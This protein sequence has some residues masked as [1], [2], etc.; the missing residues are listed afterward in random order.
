MQ[1]DYQSRQR[2]MGDVLFLFPVLRTLKTSSSPTARTLGRGTVHFPYKDTKSLTNKISTDM[3]FPDK[4][5]GGL[6]SGGTTTQ[7][8]LQ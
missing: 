2:E 7:T 1:Y 5:S 8:Q 6:V 3:G 4:T